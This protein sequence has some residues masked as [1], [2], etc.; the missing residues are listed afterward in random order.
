[1]INKFAWIPLL[2]LV[3][4]AC[5]KTETTTT[6]RYLLLKFKFND[7]IPRLNSLGNLDTLPNGHWAVSPSFNGI[8]SHFVELSPSD[9]T[10]L[11]KGAVL[12]LGAISG[13][14]AIDFSKSIITKDG[15]TFLQVPLSSIPA[16]TYKWL[17][18]SLSYQNYDVPYKLDTTFGNISFYSVYNG[19]IASFIGF[20]THFNNDGYLIK[21]LKVTDVANQTKTQGYWGFETTVGSGGF[22]FPAITKTGQAPANATTVVNPL[23]ASSPVPQGSCVVTARFNQIKN[24]K[25][26]YVGYDSTVVSNL[27]IT[28]KETQSIT[29]ECNL[30]TN[31]SFEWRDDNGDHFWQPLKGEQVI[32][33]GMR[34]MKPIIK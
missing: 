5:T 27:V 21:H 34:G 24:N 10:P 9:S 16:G 28:G 13:D 32:D 11:G 26:G 18:V 31:K 29:V 7:T 30:S 25:L 3:F 12:F 19:T 8:S 6:E 33:M 23:F 17:R 14:S 4:V 20:K 1:M 15:E 2:A 22:T